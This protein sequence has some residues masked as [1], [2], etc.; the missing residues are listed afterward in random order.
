MNLQNRGKLSSYFTIR[1]YLHI[2]SFTSEQRKSSCSSYTK[3]GQKMMKC[4]EVDYKFYIN[5]TQ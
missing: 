3:K 2:P 5:T 1:L 4:Q